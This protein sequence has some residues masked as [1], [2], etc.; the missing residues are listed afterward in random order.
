M[1][2]KKTDKKTGNVVKF[3]GIPVRL[4][5]NSDK[6]KTYAFDV[7]RKAYPGIKQNK[8]RNVSVIGD[9]PELNLGAEYIVE[10]EEEDTK[11]G[12]S[13]RAFSI[14]RDTPTTREGVLKFLCEVLTNRQAHVLYEQYPDII[15]I[16]KDGR[17]EEVDLSKLNGIGEVRF[18]QIKEKIVKDL[19]LIDL[20]A[21]YG[22]VLTMSTIKK[23]YDK[24]K[25][26]DMVRGK[27]KKEPHTTFT[28][29]SGIGFLT[30]D[31]NVLDLQDNNIV[32][33]GYDVR[34]SVDRCRACAIYVL[35]EN[36]KDGHT[37][38]NLASLRSECIKMVPECASTFADAIQCDDIFYNKDMMVVS[39]SRA[40]Y[41]EYNIAKALIEALSDNE[42][43]WDFD[44]EKYRMVEGLP[45]SDEQMRAVKNV[46]D[47]KVSIINGAAGTGKSFCTQAIISML[48]D[49][50]KT[51]KMMSPTG[52]AAKVLAD[53]TKR[54][55]TT[56][57]RGLGLTKD[58]VG[59]SEDS[60]ITADVVI[61]DEFSMVDIWLFAHLLRAIDFNTTRLLI[62]GDNSQLCS[63]GCGNLLHDLMMSDLV[64]T[65]TLT[66]VFRYED[67]GLMKIATDVR[68]S[69]QYLDSDMKG[70][71]TTFGTNKD[72]TFV[73]V[74]SDAVPMQVVSLYKKMM[75]SGVSRDNIQVLTAKNVG[76]CGTIALNA[77]IQ[78]VANDNFEKST[79]LV[80]GET[81]YYAGDIVIQTKN[82]Y[83]AELHPSEIDEYELDALYALDED[84]RKNAWPTAFV[85]NGESGVVIE[86]DGDTIVI[87]F[88]GIT[89]QY[90]KSMMIDVKLGYAITIHKS[91]GSSI[92]NV[93]LC[94]PQS[95]IFMLDS[96][97]IYVGLT[98]MKKRCF[99]LGSLDSVNMAVKKKA[100]LTRMTFLKDMLVEPD[101]FRPQYT[102]KTPGEKKEEGL[103]W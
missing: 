16:I 47:Y 24:Y 102:A 33:F 52:K 68:Y 79:P 6:F 23:I 22:G 5:Y 96:N 93:I 8:Y 75:E 60:A 92:D 74:K 70:K 100:N 62:I 21:E 38:M 65:T 86:T 78:K 73:D 26:V 10:A 82:N 91:Q 39:L 28:K 41:T 57:H 51:Y 80:F 81:C 63:V 19:H 1:T 7:D 31:Q 17:E 77:M 32:D 48:D 43:A 27:I 59:A 20:V 95:H 40:F 64:P 46:C 66:N 25:T 69:K 14:G 54:R 30:A 85:A 72:Y 11:Y 44:V 84:D 99:H 53:Y 94:T 29:I 45:L 61:V 49:N 34:Q 4:V 56:I 97:L 103:P 3:K 71:A 90:E 76:D 42:S 98:R 87:D 2:A 89:V 55:V 15:D 50:E 35:E 13:Y 37:M 83:G 88:G 101:K 67:G 58:S 9:I 18:A 36:Q 12:V